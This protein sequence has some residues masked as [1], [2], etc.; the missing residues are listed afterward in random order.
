MK[1]DDVVLHKE[2]T[3]EGYLGVDIEQEGKKITF[4]QAGLTKRIIE[5][6]GLNTKYSTAKST[7]ADT[8]AL[9]KDLNGPPAKGEINYAQVIGMLLYLNH[10]HPDILFATHQCAQYTF[11][12]KLSHKIALVQI[13]QYL[14]GAID[15]RLIL[16]LSNK[17][18]LNCYPDADFAGLWNRDNKQDPHCVRSCTRYVICL[19]DCPVL[20]VS[21]LQTEIV[22]STM[23]A[24]YVSLNTSC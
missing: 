23:E 1:T 9:G 18:K 4:T 6:L 5:A 7:P 17:I 20:W 19:S 21:K 3:A 11:A 8:K 2:G 15:N 12:P 16:Q 10:S 13:G 14:K 24:E 22:L